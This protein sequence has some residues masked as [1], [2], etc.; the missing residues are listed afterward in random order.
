MAETAHARPALPTDVAGEQ[1]LEAISPHPNRLLAQ[2]DAALEEQVLDIAQ[3][4]LKPHVHHHDQANDLGRG[5]EVME[6]TGRFAGAWHVCALAVGFAHCR[7]VQL[8]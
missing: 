8:L 1:R 3:R 7:S 4:Q 5:V 2:F 6:R